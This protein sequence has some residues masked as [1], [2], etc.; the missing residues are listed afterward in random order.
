M[1]L[2]QVSTQPPKPDLLNSA[3]AEYLSLVMHKENGLSFGVTL[4]FITVQHNS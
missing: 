2:D 1:I 4:A 3:F